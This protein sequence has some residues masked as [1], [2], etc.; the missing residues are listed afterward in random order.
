MPSIQECLFQA[1]LMIELAVADLRGSVALG[2]PLWDFEVDE[3]SERLELAG[4]I[5]RKANGGIG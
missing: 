5:I 1:G 3:I 4:L 2:I